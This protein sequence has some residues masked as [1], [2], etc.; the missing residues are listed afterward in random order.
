MA[1]NDCPG[2][3]IWL[4]SDMRRTRSWP[5]WRLLASALTAKYAA[6]FDRFFGTKAVVSEKVDGS[7][8]AGHLIESEDGGSRVLLV[9]PA[10]GARGSSPRLVFWY[11]LSG[12]VTW[13]RPR[14]CRCT[15]NRSCGER[16]WSSRSAEIADF[17]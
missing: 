11:Q 3:S 10:S 4:L 2:P 1:L 15:L 17:G 16:R 5:Y 13:Y 6:R 7:P 9:A 12:L 8:V 14:T